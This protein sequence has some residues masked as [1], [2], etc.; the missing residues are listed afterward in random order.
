MYVLTCINYLPDNC[1]DTPTCR[2]EMRESDGPTSDSVDVYLGTFAAELGAGLAAD[3]GLQRFFLL[4][5]CSRLTP[6][7]DLTRQPSGGGLTAA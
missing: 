4:L 1:D 6:W 3:A 2:H 5:S 7:Y